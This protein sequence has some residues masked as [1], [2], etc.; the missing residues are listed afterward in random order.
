MIC[1]NCGTALSSGDQNP[2]SHGLR[3]FLDD[4]DEER[5]TSS[6]SRRTRKSGERRSKFIAGLLAF[7]FGHFG[8]HWFYLGESQRGG[9][10]LG[11]T[12]TG[13]ILTT[14]FLVLSDSFVGIILCGII[15]FLA[16][17]D[18]IGLF[19]MD[20]DDFEKKYNR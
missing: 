17:I 19:I 10:Y 20:D 9:W 2:I 4:I 8:I 1:I 11:L 3:N 15:A 16:L 13:F 5:L 12:I 6:G 7:F 14:V 18:A